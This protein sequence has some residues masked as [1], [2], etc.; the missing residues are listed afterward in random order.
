MN[1]T[2]ASVERI[3]VDV[4]FREIPGRHMQ[5]HLAYWSVSEVC[6]VTLSNGVVGWGETLPFYTWGRVSEEACGRVIGRNPLE[7]LWDDSLGAGLQM[8]LW[9]AAGRALEMPCHVLMGPPV[10]EACPLSWWCIDMPAEDWA[11]EAQEA[12]AQGYTH[13][14]LKPRPWFD[15]YEQTEAIARVVPDYFELDHDFNGFL[16]DASRALPVLKRLEEYPHVKMFET[17][18]PQQDVAGYRRLRAA[19]ER[20][21][22]LHYGVPSIDVALQEE[23]C[24]G[25]VLGGGAFRLRQQA[26]LCAEFRKPF[27]LQLVG[28][29]ITTAWTLQLGA[30][31]AYARWSAITCLNLYADDLIMEPIQVQGGFAQLP[32]GPGLGVIVDQEALERYRI[33]PPVRKEFPRR[34]FIVRFGDGHATCF[35]NADAYHDHFY[36]SNDPLFQPGTRLETWED[37]GSPEFQDLYQRA[38]RGPVRLKEG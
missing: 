1:L 14:K 35:A 20:P 21:I 29:G 24:D 16:R 36:A 26:A 2:V 32:P 12:V 10:R 8:A 19:V 9:D 3:W 17:P 4:P 15:V 6:K 37:D 33:E 13:L 18:I 34:L 23:I 25:F 27:W 7:L 11:A 31:F 38:Q 22:A 30:T 5:R 28:T